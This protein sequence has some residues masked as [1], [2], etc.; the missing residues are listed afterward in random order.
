MFA[1]TLAWFLTKFRVER[2][3]SLLPFVPRLAL[4]LLHDAAAPLDNACVRA[5]DAIVLL[6]D[7][8]GFTGL[9]DAVAARDGD[10]G[11]ERLQ[12][13]LNDC[14]GPLTDLVDAAGG[15]VLAFPGDAALAIWIRGDPEPHALARLAQRGAHCGLQLRDRLDRR[16]AAGHAEL[17]L[18]VAIGAGPARAALIG[19]VDNHWEAVVQGDAIEQLGDTLSAARPGE[20]LLSPAAA[21]LCGPAVEG[22]RRGSHLVVATARLPASL[23]LTPSTPPPPMADALVRSLVARS[24]RARFDAG[25]HA[26]LAEFRTVTAVFIHLDP[27]AARDIQSLQSSIHLI[28]ELVSRFDGDVNQVVADEK[29]LTVVVAFGLVQQTHEDDAARAVRASLEIRNELLTHSVEARFGIATGRVFTGGR[30]GGARVEFAILGPPVVLAARLSSAADAILCDAATQAACQ[31]AISFQRALPVVLKGKGSVADVWQ[32]VGVQ[33]RVDRQRSGIVGRVAERRRIDERLAALEQHGAGGVVVL[34]G[35]PGIGKTTLIAAALQ[36]ARS[37]RLTCLTGAGDSI[38]RDTAYRTWREIVA[39][40]LGADFVRDAAAVRRRLQQLLPDEQMRWLPLLNPMLPLSFPE[41]EYT[42]PLDADS[43]ARTARDLVVALLAP[44]ASALPLLIVLEDTHWMD[45][46]SWE[47]AEDVVNRIPRLLLLLSTRV[48]VEPNEHAA[49]LAARPGAC[50]LRLGALPAEEIRELVSRRIL[51]EGLSNELADWIHHRSEGH[52]L[53]AEELALALRDRGA[54]DIRGGTGHLRVDTASGEMTALPGTVRGVV[55][56]R[57]DRLSPAEQLTLKVAAVIGH[58]FAIAELTA[59]HPLG[60]A[61]EGLLGH[62]TH[63]TSTGLL[64]PEPGHPGLFSF[65]H[66]L[67]QEVAY[68]LLPYAQ[69]SALHRRTAESLERTADASAAELSPL[70][71]HH[72]DRAEVADRAMHYLE[73]AGEQALLRDAS[74]P[75]AEKFLT[76]LIQLADALAA[77]GAPT[78]RRAGRACPVDPSRVALAKWERMLSQ[79]L[80]RQGRHA[81]AMGHLERSIALLGHKMPAATAANRF[82]VLRGLGVRLAARPRAGRRRAPSAPEQAAVLEVVRAYDSFVQFLYLGQAEGP[83][84]LQPGP[85]G[86]K[87]LLSAVAL[88]RSARLAELVGPSGELSRTYSLVANLVAMFRRP[89]L[90]DYY[91]VRAREIAEQIHDKHALFRALTMGQLPAFICG[92]WDAAEHN[93]IEGLALGWELRNGHECLIHECTLGYLC[94]HQGRLD[95]AYARFADI[96]AR[97]DAAADQIPRLWA[98]IAIAEVMLRQG[99]LPD[100]IAKAR[101][102]LDMADASGT[103]D[104]NSRF[105]AYGLLAAAC[106]RQ[107]SLS[108]AMTHV[109]HATAAADAGARLSY[110]SQAGFVGVAEALLAEFDCSP[111]GRRRVDAPLRRWL[112]S[113]RAVA[114]CRPI[115]EPWDLFYRAAWNQR[116]GRRR[117]AVRQL[118]KAVRVADGMALPYESAAARLALERLAH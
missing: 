73:R 97:A 49:R 78:T 110:S 90:A 102:C 77:P 14:F 28:Q 82:E 16:P 72:W 65:S 7:V 71:A 118:K 86:D 84:K 13:I 116:H 88:L 58:R 99:R 47:L 114:F 38:E 37:R 31:Q 26:W 81:A 108:D 117:L 32:P 56:S 75:E 19:G 60:D 36:S 35:E 33:P 93:L 74:N 80:A 42:S 107:G 30:G 98:T 87:A 63:V 50:V 41:N 15:E 54:L 2:R 43:R 94:F 22:A 46:S 101:E 115:L 17:R 9:V 57:I 25:Q 106:A 44:A 69:R 52:P 21:A 111:G 53:F 34:E 96:R 89:E 104:Q 76:R 18:R 105:Q 109:A 64:Y 11:A 20:V 3:M 79:A 62:L 29:G 66:A 112:W 83:G 59:V 85:R 1:Q 68:D 95:E 40:I 23:A 24:V 55:A 61:G 48:A 103:I 6:A 39:A 100:A 4:S 91:A 10:R 51:V 45:S 113:L 92:R 5:V 70:L 8:S 12:G 67:V 27:R